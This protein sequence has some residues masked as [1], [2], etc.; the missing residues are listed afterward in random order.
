MKVLVTGG[1]GF[2]GSYVVKELL[3]YGH[4]I[5]LFAR[6]ANK[7]SGF[8]EHEHI[9]FVTGQMDDANAIAKA[10]AEQDA[11][12]HIALSWLDGTAEETLVHETMPSVRLFQM[13]HGYSLSVS[14]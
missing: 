5:T 9:R 7:V 1:T 12:V 3:L 10:L 11:C 8:V 13:S 2:I 4:E 6:N 14:P